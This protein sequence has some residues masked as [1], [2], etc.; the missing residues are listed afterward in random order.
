MTRTWDILAI[1][2][3]DTYPEF[4]ALRLATGNEKDRQAIIRLSYEEVN[5]LFLILSVIS[6]T[7][8]QYKNDIKE[9]RKKEL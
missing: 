7:P 9:N 1:E 3:P 5:N 4:Y 8:E 2:E 6:I